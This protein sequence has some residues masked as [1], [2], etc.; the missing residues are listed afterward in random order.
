MGP[1]GGGPRGAGHPVAQLRPLPTVGLLD[2]RR[3]RGARRA[4][5][6]R[7]VHRPCPGPGAGGPLGRG[8]RGGPVVSR[9]RRRAC[10]DPPAVRAAHRPVPGDQAPPG[11]HAGRGGAV[12]GG[13][14][15]R[16]LG[17]GPRCGGPRRARPPHRRPTGTS[18][19]GTPRSDW[20]SGWPPPWPWTA[21]WRRP[22]EPS[23]CSGAWASP[24]STTP[25]STCVGPPPCDRWSGARLRFGP[26]RPGW[27]WRAGAEHWP[28]SS[29]PRPIGCAGN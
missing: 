9:H 15:G 18:P 17:G 10:P 13:H 27:R 3:G 16:S 19:I 21:T 7:G 24:G 23:R 8:G 14:V 29:R 26:R 28:S 2:A 4:H 20:P 12:G 25:T 11:R 6:R 1:V 22:R 5:A